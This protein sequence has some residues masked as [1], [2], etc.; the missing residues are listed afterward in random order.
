MGT[1]RHA[2]LPVWGLVLSGGQGLRA[3]GQDKG[4]LPFEGEPMALRAARRLQKQVDTVC[5][6]A[7]RNLDIYRAWG[8][9]VWPDTAF[10][11][12]DAS[13]PRPPEPRG[14]VE[15]AGPLAG[16]WT[17]LNRLG[18]RTG[19]LAVAPCDYPCLPEDWVATLAQALVS[20]GEGGRLAIARTRERS[21]WC[22]QV[23]NLSH[24]AELTQALIEA[25][26]TQNGRVQAW[27]AM[28]QAQQC[29]WP[30]G[31]AWTNRNRL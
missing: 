15:Y 8:L 7:N 12:P 14:S 2:H 30:E 1:E 21:H 6:S 17:A 31:T 22:V 27:A 11:L 24:H 16:I 4:L 19:L 18:C 23:M 9:E 10:A 26:N 5:I 29:E 28:C 13:S 25:L 20:G 3:G